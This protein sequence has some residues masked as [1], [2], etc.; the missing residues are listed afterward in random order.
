MLPFTLRVEL[1]VPFFTADQSE[2]MQESRKK[3][4]IYFCFS[5]SPT[6]IAEGPSD[7]RCTACPPGYEGQYCQR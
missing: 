2:M 1:L 3:S 4:F 6:C 7:Y 5:F